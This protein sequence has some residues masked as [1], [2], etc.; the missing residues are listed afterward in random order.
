MATIASLRTAPMVRPV[1]VRIIQERSS[2]LLNMIRSVEQLQSGAMSST[3]HVFNDP[4]LR[5]SAVQ[6][7]GNMR[8]QS[9]GLQLVQ[10]LKPMLDLYV[11]A[12]MGRITSTF[13]AAALGTLYQQHLEG[14]ANAGDGIGPSLV[15]AP[16]GEGESDSATSTSLPVSPDQVQELQR[17]AL[18]ERAARSLGLT[19]LALAVLLVLICVVLPLGNLPLMLSMA[20]AG[21]SVLSN[22]IAVAM[23]IVSVVLGGRLRD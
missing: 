17:R 7:L 11:H 8:M 22:E 16:R 14:Q 23:A 4:R 5:F 10:S 20:P 3:L 21:E 2:P 18:F 12:E 1:K 13:D 6:V 19:P 15:F 9:P